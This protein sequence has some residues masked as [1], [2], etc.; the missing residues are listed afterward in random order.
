M[1]NKGYVQIY[2][3]DGKGKTTA[4]LGLALRAVGAGLRV[5]FIKFLKGR[6]SSEDRLLRKLPGLK[7]LWFG[8]E[9]FLRGRP[10]ALDKSQA[11]AGLAAV[12]AALAG[13][14]CDLVIADEICVAAALGVIAEEDVLACIRRRPRGIELVLTGRGAT[15][16]L[17][18]AADLV[19]EM[20]AVKHYFRSGVRARRGV[21]Y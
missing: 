10:T 11:R 2:T 8:Q 3:G 5:C 14:A 1:K 21:E 13:G 20:K 9:Q 18:R 17:R 16:R 7:L 4:A 12:S 19:T 6:I 15:P